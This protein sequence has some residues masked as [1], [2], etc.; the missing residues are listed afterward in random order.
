MKKDWMIKESQI[1]DKGQTE[2]IYATNDKSCIV[3]GS[4]GT[5]KSV[6]ALIKAQ[7]IQKTKG[8]NYKIIVFTKSL[9]DYMNSGRNELGLRNVFLYH[10]DWKNR[11]LCCPTDYIIVDEIQDFDTDEIQEF[12]NAANKNFFFFG[13]SAQ[14]VYKGVLYGDR[15]KNPLP[16]ANIQNL[17]PDKS[18]LKKFELYYNYRLPVHVAE[19]VQYVG[20]NLPPFD[21]DIYKSTESSVPYMLDYDDLDSQIF[22]IKKIYESEKKRTDSADVAVLLPNNDEVK[23][24][25]KILQKQNVSYE[26]KYLNIN[27]LNFDTPNLKVMTYVSAKGLQFE[28]VILPFMDSFVNDDNTR[29]RALYVAMTRT[30][31]DLYIMYRGVLPS[32][33][34]SIPQKLYKVKIE[35]DVIEEM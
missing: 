30:Y 32:L 34:R 3:T 12:I 25:C 19:F 20:I 5:G 21:P 31:K 16:I 11:M 10:W 9:C 27:T 23:K 26:C 17:V 13:D 4:A 18:R 1:K 14:S 33:L 28:K 22:A 7:R 24:F 35:N 6:M 29:R 15:I 2:F 8:D